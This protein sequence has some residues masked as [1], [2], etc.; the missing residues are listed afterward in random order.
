MA[1]LRWVLLA[2]GVMLVAGIYV[3][4]RGV[5]RRSGAER[6]RGRRRNEPRI[7]A[8]DEPVSDDVLFGTPQ[9]G[10]L[11][12][13]SGDDDGDGVASEGPDEVPPQSQEQAEEQPPEQAPP[14]IEKIVA[15]RFVPRQ[16]E[17][18]AA[19]AVRALRDEGL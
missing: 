2:L 14:R 8:G 3:W 7:A 12:A 13:A 1:E 18:L 10:A 4:G 15:L 5:F 9:G 16:A 6:L 17:L 11:V 19:E